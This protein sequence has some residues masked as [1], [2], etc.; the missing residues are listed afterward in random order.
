MRTSEQ[1]WS[2]IAWD[3][4]L[5]PARFVV[6]VDVHAADPERVPLPDFV[7]G[8]DIPWHRVLFFELDGV[9][10]WDRT[11]L[12]RLDEIAASGTATPRA[13]GPPLWEPRRWT[14]T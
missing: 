5:D 9:R 10:C 13:L 4:R 7:P 3:P 2:Q 1:A 6:G 11:G 14:G 12:D 8:G